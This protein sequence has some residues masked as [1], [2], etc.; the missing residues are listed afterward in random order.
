MKWLL[1][2]PN[3]PWTNAPCDTPLLNADPISSRAASNA[4]AS[5]SVTTYSPTVCSARS[6]PVLS[7]RTKSLAVTTSAIV[8]A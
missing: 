6:T 4:P 5:D 7:C 2:E 1:P 3:E 8:K